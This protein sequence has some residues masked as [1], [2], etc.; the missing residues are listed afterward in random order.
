MGT[1]FEKRCNLCYNNAT[2]LMT[3]SAY[4]TLESRTARANRVTWW[5]VVV[6][7]VLVLAKVV[8]GILG[9]SSA[10]IADALHSVSDFA[11]DFA[12]LIGMRLAQRPQDGD[13]P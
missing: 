8:A 3:T 5:S 6:N 9:H 1:F 12:V 10:L 7:A 2:A 13:H 4:D 11:T